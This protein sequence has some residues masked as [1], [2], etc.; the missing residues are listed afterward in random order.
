MKIYSLKRT[1]IP[2]IA[3]LATGL[4]AAI[5]VATINPAPAQAE[6]SFGVT[7]TGCHTAG[8]SVTATPSSPTVAP[9][10]AY[11]VAIVITNAASGNSGYN[12]SLAGASVLV[13]AP[14]AGKTFS[15]AMTAP[16]AAGT[17]TYNVGADTGA[18]PGA[19]SAT[20]YSITV[21]APPT[22]TPP[23][24]TTTT[25]PADHHDDNPARRPPRRQ[26]RRRPP[27]RQ[28]PPP[29]TT[30]TTPPPT[31]TT[32]TPPPTTTTT[33]PPPTTTTTTP[34]PP[35][36]TPP[37]PPKPL[38]R[39]HPRVVAQARRHWNQGDDPRQW[40][41]TLGAVQFGTVAATASSWTDTKIVFEVPDGIYAHV[42]PVTVTPM[43]ATA[44]NAVNFRLDWD[45]HHGDDACEQAP[46]HHVRHAG[47]FD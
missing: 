39:A 16:A 22:T 17:Y 4:T 30:T 45:N 28:P 8:G 21:G 37:P 18:P 44:S 43:S 32:T 42:V 25:T 36:P 9:G 15:A 46:R 19:A 40:L 29:T 2:K 34:P 13:G 11:T 6:P 41:R 24:T 7:C 47:D 10:A 20:T 5:L 35:P 23:P 33:T 3:V 14:A 12:I 1:T 38:D 26:P 31:T 27:R